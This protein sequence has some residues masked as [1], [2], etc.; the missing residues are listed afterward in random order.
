MSIRD[1]LMNQIRTQKTT[2][3]V[4]GNTHLDFAT[5]KELVVG[6]TLEQDHEVYYVTKVTSKV[7]TLKN[8]RTGEFS[9]EPE[10]FFNNAK[11]KKVAVSGNFTY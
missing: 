1:Q 7:V 2:N 11:F 5:F 4:C 10:Y 3:K 6:M 9:Y 8:L